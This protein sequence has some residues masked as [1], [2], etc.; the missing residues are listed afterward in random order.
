MPDNV[1]ASAGRLTPN[2]SVVGAPTWLKCHGPQPLRDT[3][4]LDMHDMAGT[5]A[6]APC[7]GA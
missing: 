7:S 4:D 3:C 2:D 5:L 6:H 1:D